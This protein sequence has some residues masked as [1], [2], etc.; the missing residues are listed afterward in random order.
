VGR[1]GPAPEPVA[2]KLA[3]GETRP[4]RVNYEAPIPR[5]A[6]PS[7][8]RSM[9]GAAKYVWK[10]VISEQAPGVILAVDRYLLRIYCEAVVRYEQAAVAYAASS[11]LVNNRGHL[12]KNP[13]HQV[14]RDNAEQVRL[15]ARELGLSPAARAGLRMDSSRPSAGIEQEIGLP[16]RLRVVGGE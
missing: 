1:H 6:R 9:S 14:V 16:P 11:V 4:S 15:F 10:R 3:R 7:V 2:A 8:P 12:T 5:Q 13:L